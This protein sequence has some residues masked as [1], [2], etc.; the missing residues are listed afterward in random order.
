MIPPKCE[1]DILCFG[2]IPFTALSVVLM[3]GSQAERD[4]TTACVIQCRG[5][6]RFW[7]GTWRKS[8][9]GK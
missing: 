2:I 9:G 4:G 1:F 8:A 7:P 5:E 3:S 6:T